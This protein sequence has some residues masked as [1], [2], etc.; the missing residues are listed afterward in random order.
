MKVQKRNQFQIF[1]KLMNNKL[2]KF[3]K[4]KGVIAKQILKNIDK[5]V[6]FKQKINLKMNKSKKMQNNIKIQ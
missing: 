3:K 6:L 4:V 1:K 2:I 5:M